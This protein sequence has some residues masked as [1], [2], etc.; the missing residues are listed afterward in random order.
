MYQ[1]LGKIG[2]N[3]VFPLIS[4]RLFQKLRRWNSLSS[5][6]F[7]GGFNFREPAF[8]RRVSVPG[9]CLEDELGKYRMIRGKKRR[10]DDF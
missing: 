9:I 5:E 3:P 10:I 8:R 4:R 1:V 6:L 7:V 2:Q